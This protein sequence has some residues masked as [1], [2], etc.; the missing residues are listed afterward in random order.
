[1]AEHQE[2]IKC[3]AWSQSPKKADAKVQKFCDEVKTAVEEKINS[4]ELRMFR[5]LDYITQ[6]VAGQNYR[7]RVQIN[8]VA[9][10]RIQVFQAPILSGKKSPPRLT[11]EAND[12]PLNGDNWK[13]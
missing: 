4:P 7:I 3:G 5:A 9:V 13:Q 2:A 11:D 6:V 10:I 1:M 12:G 8:N